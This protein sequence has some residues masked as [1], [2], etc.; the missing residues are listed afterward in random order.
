MEPSVTIKFYWDSRRK[1][2][3]VLATR[4]GTHVLA[5]TTVDHSVSLDRESAELLVTAC[6][7]EMRSWLF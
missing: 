6:A 2:W 3:L 5:R 4:A 7:T 1:T